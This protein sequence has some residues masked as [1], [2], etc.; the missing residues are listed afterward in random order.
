MTAC[1][2]ERGKEK[3]NSETEDKCRVG[4]LTSQQ[5]LHEEI[6]LVTDF[7]TLDCAFFASPAAFPHASEAPP[8]GIF[9]LALRA[10]ST[11]EL[12]CVRDGVLADDSHTHPFLL[13][14][15]AY[16]YPILPTFTTPPRA[17][18]LTVIS[19]HSRPPHS[20]PWRRSRSK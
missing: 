6:V 7:I 5:Q 12:Q 17:N 1:R 9:V 18:C 2:A 19:T 3:K 16:S 11:P 14:V 4:E 15:S 20:T 8:L 13:T 10:R